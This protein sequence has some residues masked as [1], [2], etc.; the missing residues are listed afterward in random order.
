MKF[1]IISFIILSFTLLQF[2]VGYTQSTLSDKKENVNTSFYNDIIV[3][4][5]ELNGIGSNESE[6]IFIGYYKGLQL[7]KEVEDSLKLRFYDDYS[8]AMYTLHLYD[9]S[10][11]LA[12][13]GIELSKTAPE[14]IPI[15][16]YYNDLAFN[17]AELKKYDSVTW[18]YKMINK[19]NEKNKDYFQSI[20]SYNNLG[21]HYYLNLKKYDS[22][23]IFLKK[24]D[25]HPGRV[26]DSSLTLNWSI[27]DNIALVYMAQKR[28]AEASALFKENYEH[29]TQNK[30][31]YL[32][33]ERWLRAGL[34]YAEVEIIQEN[35]LHAKKILQEIEGHLTNL[36][37]Y[38]D[39][40]NEYFKSKLLLLK[41][42][43]QF[44]QA[45]RDFE[46]AN[47]LGITYH[48]LKDSLKRSEEEHL[49]K[50]YNLIREIG[51]QN[52]QNTLQQEQLINKVEKKSLE[53]DL[54]RRSTRI[55][56]LLAIGILV[57]ILIFGYIYY[58]KMQLY[59]KN[60][61]QLQEA[62]AQN[63]IK[64]QEKQRTRIARELHDSVG[65]KLMLLSQKTRTANDP[66]MDIL[67]KETLEELRNALKGL[68]PA[69]IEK[70]GISTSLQSLVNQVDANTSIFFTTE[71]D[72]V[73]DYFTKEASLHLY[74]IIQE[75][76]NNIVKHAD[77][78]S[79]Y[80]SVIKED[81]SIKTVIKDNGKGFNFEEKYNSGKSLGMKTLLE[82]AKIIN[83]KIEINSVLGKGT[84][85]ILHTST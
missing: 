32:W 82:R 81:Q 52:A 63:L 7:L 11:K 69:I 85:V 39:S 59:A 80:V 77:T 29:Y 68:H 46:R 45:T 44:A 1:S 22:A 64:S 21:Y 12:K 3:G 6:D 10:I 55:Y 65:Q 84:T 15:Q 73:D 26:F 43:Q 72:K 67:A 51:L 16:N 53:L 41:T 60:K 13:K 2:E 23:L 24:R 17:Y 74:R 38:R 33:R 40:P 25:K 76:L 56:W 35:F 62:Y 47:L 75:L 9:E 54:K 27:N 71:I 49:L 31:G 78:K 34:Q 8:F 50:D 18:A 30:R 37:N 42:K 19:E 48:K 66:S 61:E 79:V 14:Y 36:S 70:L 4:A 28:Y 58:R 20:S 5:R 83:S 57:S